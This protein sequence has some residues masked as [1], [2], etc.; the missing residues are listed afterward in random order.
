[1]SNSAPE[2]AAV[3][4][5]EH[6]IVEPSS[7][8]QY[9][10][11]NRNHR[12]NWLIIALIGLA[13][14]SFWF[15][16][17]TQPIYTDAYYY[18]TNGQQLASGQGFS[19]MI[20]WQ[21]LDDPVGLPA[22][23]HT[24]WM[25]L[26]SILAAAGYLLV[27]DFNGAQLLFWLLGGLL[28]VLAYEISRQLGGQRWQGWVT[29]LFAAIGGF[30][31]PFLIQPSTF[32]P[33]A[34]AGG[35]CLLALGLATARDGPQES[36]PVLSEDQSDSRRLMWWMV[37]GLT[38]G[39]AHLTRADGLL[40]LF[41]GVLIWLLAV[42]RRRRSMRFALSWLGLL[43]AGYL[44]VMGWW[45]LRNWLVIGSPLPTAG[46]QSIFLTTYDDLFAFG[47]VI[48]LEGFINWGWANILR[49]RLDALWVAIQTLIAVSGLIF[50]VPFIIV[51]LFRYYRQ[52]YTRILLLPALLFAI[53]TMAIL[54]PLFSFPAMRGS[55][56]HSSI[57]LWPWTTALAVAGISF[58]VD[59]AAARLP[60]W[61][62]ER[63]KRLF[64]ILFII[65]AVVMTGADA[66]NKLTSLK[67]PE[68]L[69]LIIKELPDSAVVMVGD[70][71]A[72]NY[73]SG[74]PAISIPNEPPNVLLE[75]A[76]RY[77]VTYVVLDENYPQPL[78]DIHAGLSIHPR[79]QLERTVGETKLFRIIDLAPQ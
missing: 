22:P 79:L 78:A 10:G 43:L 58:S 56:F 73:H 38:A 50:L 39:L 51:A 18:T 34:W 9:P 1:M 69:Q 33:F 74:L 25:P 15:W 40:L 35:L 13:I 20:I 19:E 55:F 52:R 36:N 44:L 60:H 24:Y 4:T 67:D 53:T 49:S 2:P 45:F 46:T 30:Y 3:K 26:P 59:W 28:P 68:T 12:L 76:D 70:A 57:A 63:A 75:A 8:D 47:R 42:R 61:R 5:A 6:G 72:F 27:D 66:Q 65:I 64:S 7:D 31:A 71:P 17:L 37:A 11:R 62:P 16:R 54:V 14:Q 48:S 21:F 77:G 23:S 29:A 32:A 41:V